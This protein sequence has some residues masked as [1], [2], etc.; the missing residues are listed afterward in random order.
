MTLR[1]PRL[2]EDVQVQI[3]DVISVGQV[4]FGALSAPAAVETC[5]ILIAE[6]MTLDE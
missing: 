4:T 6:A 5:R 3:E 2:R 1:K